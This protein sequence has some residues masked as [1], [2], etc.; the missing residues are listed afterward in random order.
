M[1]LYIKNMV[2]LKCKLVVKEELRNL[3][4]F[5]AIVGLWCCGDS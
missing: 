3:G 2:G 1:T 4:L 5:C